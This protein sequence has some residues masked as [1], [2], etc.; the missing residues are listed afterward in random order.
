MIPTEVRVVQYAV[1]C[2]SSSWRVN[3][4]AS[5]P[6]D[7]RKSLAARSGSIPGFS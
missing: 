4:R 2:A 6:T 3:I 1:S 7:L 5:G